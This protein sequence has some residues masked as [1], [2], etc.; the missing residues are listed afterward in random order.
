[1]AGVA[2]MGMCPVAADLA[3]K[4]LL[5]TK[6]LSQKVA[7]HLG[8]KLLAPQLAVTNRLWQ[9]NEESHNRAG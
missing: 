5:T 3:W 9:G 7:V 1:M 6:I 4:R 8:Q 2:V